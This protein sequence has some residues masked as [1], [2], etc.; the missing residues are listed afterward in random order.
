MKKILLTAFVA[1]GFIFAASAQQEPL[2]AKLNKQAVAA[3]KAEHATIQKYKMDTEKA[4]QQ[5]PKPVA[6]K[7]ETADRTSD[8]SKKN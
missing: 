5:T 3:K 1:L 8:A 7:P 4:A 2:K 6:A